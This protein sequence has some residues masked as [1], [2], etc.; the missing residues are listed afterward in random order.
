[1][2][3]RE[4]TKKNEEKEITKKMK[5]DEPEKDIMKNDAKHRETT[6]NNYEK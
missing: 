2:K 3:K 4:K 6:M 1:M 5:N